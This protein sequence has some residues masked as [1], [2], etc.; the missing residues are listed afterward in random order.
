MELRNIANAI[1]IDS[2][3]E[4][5]EAVFAALPCSDGS[6]C[7]LDLID[8][9][10]EQWILFGE[11]YE[12]VRNT[13]EEI[14][15]DE[16]RSAWIK[17]ALAY[18]MDRTV[19]EACKVPAPKADGTA[20]TA[21]L[22]LYIL[23]PMFPLA[24]ADYLRRGFTRE[25]IARILQ[26]IPAGIRV[27]QSQTGMPGVD[28]TYYGWLM[29]FAKARIF[30]ADQLQIE[31]FQSPD[32]VVYLKHKV[33]GQLCPL[34]YDTLI[35]RSGENLVGSV[36][37]EDAQGATQAKFRE[38]ADN[39][40]GYPCIDDVI[41][42]E[43]QAFPKTEWEAFL[44]PGDDCL[45]MHIPAGTDISTPAMLRYFELGRKIAKERYPEHKGD[46][47]Y[48][49]SWI[50]DPRLE[51]IMGPESNIVKMLKLFVKYPLKTDGNHMFGFIF[52]GKPNNYEDL[53]EKSTLQRGMKK[54]LLSG[55]HN[56]P[57]A[58]IYKA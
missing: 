42:T 29:I 41:H 10:Q 49:I 47:I 56:Y 54:L 13:A 31:I 33:S 16:N 32:H 50:L 5:L 53:P 9:L 17:T 45:N 3:P 51:D 39:F 57:H 20:A 22:P 48:A 8:K 38:D 46:A 4:E 14:N 43:E 2:Y 12:V 34:F 27:V 15:R 11:F 23:I 6:A 18:G 58:G 40:Y 25:E 28:D 7:D 35:H 55:G 21:L 44:R 24:V 52:G 26:G 19:E 36:G 30:F 1:G 37:Y